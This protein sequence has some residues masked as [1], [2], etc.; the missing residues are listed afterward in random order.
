M[1]NFR[2]L[3]KGQSHLTHVKFITAFLQFLRKVHQEPRN[4]GWIPHPGRA[5]SR[6]KPGTFWVQMQHI[7]PL[8]LLCFLQVWCFLWILMTF[9]ELLFQR[10][11][12]NI[13][14]CL[15]QLKNLVRNSSEY[16]NKNF[17]YTCG[18]CVFVLHVFKVSS[19][20]VSSEF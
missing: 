5:P 19:G 20:G 6:F 2:W 10:S 18:F 3:S 9:W 16:L 12:A 15:F 7:N 14:Y 4:K 17:L 11:L 1:T 13:Y 8:C